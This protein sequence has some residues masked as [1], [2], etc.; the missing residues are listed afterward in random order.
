MGGT[1]CRGLREE[2]SAAGIPGTSSRPNRS[3]EVG[4]IIFDHEESIDPHN[5]DC[6]APE[7]T[8]Y[9]RTLPEAKAGLIKAARLEGAEA[10]F[11]PQ[12]LELLR[13]QSVHQRRDQPNRVLGDVEEDHGHGHTGRAGGANRAEQHPG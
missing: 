1:Y 4:G 8:T 10:N 13:V 7:F 2:P 6:A 12:R 5:R 9:L 3:V 11:S